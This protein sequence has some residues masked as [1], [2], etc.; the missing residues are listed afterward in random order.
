M[1]VELLETVAQ[2]IEQRGKPVNMAQWFNRCKTAGCIAGETL[3]A[4]GADLT[5]F[6]G[7]RRTA[8]S[9]DAAALLGLD[10]RQAGRLFFYCAWP[11]E[12]RGRT[13]VTWLVAAIP[14]PTVAARIRH[15]VESGGRE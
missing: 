15:F 9:A 11:D 1:N 7:R 8:P 3:L 13:G 5:P 12:F 4:S 6:R 10:R 2:R 14:A